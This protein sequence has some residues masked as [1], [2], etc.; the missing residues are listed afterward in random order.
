MLE[1]NEYQ[2]KGLIWYGCKNN[3]QIK[4]VSSHYEQLD[5]SLHGGFPSEGI[6]ELKTPLG[7][8]ELRLLLPYLLEKQSQFD[9]E[10]MF[11]APPVQL[12]AEFFLA[13]GLDLNKI[14]VL[15]VYEKRKALWAAEQSLSS[16]CCNV[17]FL[18]QNELDI[19]QVRR[20]MLACEQG[21]SSLVLI[22]N[23]QQHSSKLLSLPSALS[24]S[25]FPSPQGIQVKIDKQKGGMASAPFLINMSNTWQDL[26]IPTSGS[27]NI[28]NGYSRS[29]NIIAFPHAVSH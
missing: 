3:D 6:I 10:M 19:K 28:E 1:L 5:K 14:I 22:R 15:P 26:T 4:K 20:F 27:A 18:W 13:N 21:S 16:G 9:G 23:V 12:N 8:G 17:V 25:L 29:N 24:L 7:I 2:N 11:I